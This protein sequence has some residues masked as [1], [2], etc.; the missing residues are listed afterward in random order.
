[1]SLEDDKRR[2]REYRTEHERIF[3]RP[4]QEKGWGT[5][6]IIEETSNG[7][8]S[9][10]MGLSRVQVETLVPLLVEWLDKE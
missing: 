8:Q 5:D 4:A 10:V 1:M 6:V 2:M 3:L 7:Y 9:H